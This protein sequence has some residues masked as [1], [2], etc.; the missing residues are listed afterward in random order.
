MARVLGR[1]AMI[2]RRIP[3]MECALVCLLL[4]LSIIGNS[5]HI[6]RTVRSAASGLIAGLYYG[7]TAPAARGVPIPK[8]V[9]VRVE[10]GKAF[11][12]VQAQA[13]RNP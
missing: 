6:D 8:T 1:A 10:T 2:G 11:N 13:G 7:E 9:V 4:A 3:S 12:S 5:T